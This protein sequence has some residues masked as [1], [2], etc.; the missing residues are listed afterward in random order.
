M[1][2]SPL[3]SPVDPGTISSGFRPG[4]RPNHT[5]IDYVTEFGAPV[6][7][8]QDGTVVY[9]GFHWNGSGQLPAGSVPNPINPGKQ[10]SAYGGYG[11]VVI[12]E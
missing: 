3:P 10:K 5:G 7:A 2:E 11:N 6:M 4:N 12:M 8:V 9:R 1:A